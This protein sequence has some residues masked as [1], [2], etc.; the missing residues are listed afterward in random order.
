MGNGEL[1]RS[2]V[3]R[4]HAGL[5]IDHFWRHRLHRAIE[6]N[7]NRIL[8]CGQSSDL[9]KPSFKLETEQTDRAGMIMDELHGIPFSFTM[10]IRS[11]LYRHSVFSNERLP[12]SNPFLGL[13]ER[14]RAKS[15]SGEPGGK[16]VEG[17]MK[18]SWKPSLTFKKSQQPSKWWEKPE[19]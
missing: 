13:T 12:L 11:W 19:I 16:K 15:A 5:E 17:G 8:E 18:L 3:M 14:V 2:D 10:C 7:Y 9:V 6:H 4:N 1:C